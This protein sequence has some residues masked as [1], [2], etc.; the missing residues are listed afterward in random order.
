LALRGNAEAAFAVLDEI[1]I[2]ELAAPIR[3]ELITALM[4]TRQERDEAL[5]R[6]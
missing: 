2:E 5:G 4:S 1:E 3:L 6:N